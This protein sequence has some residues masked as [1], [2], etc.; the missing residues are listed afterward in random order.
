MLLAFGSSAAAQ[1][2]TAI[3]LPDIGDSSEA[4]LSS[5]DDARLGQAFMRE[6]RASVDVIDD[7]EIE[8]FIQNLGYRITAGDDAR[9]HSFFFFMVNDEAINAFAGPGGHIGV[10]TGLVLATESEDELASVLAHETAHVTQRHI[11]RA[12]ENASRNNIPALAGIIAAIALGA[13]S[14]SADAG[15]A[16]ASAIAGLQ[17]QN[18]I[19]LI[20]AN[21]KEAD[22]V[23]ME[24][25]SKADFDPRAMPA[26]FEKL[27]TSSRYYRTP[28]EFLS[29]HP[30]TTSRIADSRARAERYAYRQTPGSFDYHLTV[31]KIR[32]L[33]APSPQV[34]VDYFTKIVESG[35]HRNA[36]AAAYG[37]GL[38]LAASRRYDQAAQVLGE[39]ESKHPREP[40]FK[41]ALAAMALERGRIDEAVAKYE[42]AYRNFPDNKALVF[43]Y[44]DALLRANRGAQALDVT[45]DYARAYGREGRLYKL[46]ADAY[47]QAGRPVDS[48]LALAEHLYLDGRLDAAINQLR[49]ASG[50]TRANF[51]DGSRIAARLKALEDERLLRAQ[52]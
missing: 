4:I 5:A 3:K 50:Q 29:T 34:A 44:A 14:G 9:D 13:V 52:R 22:R 46:E 37:W 40:R 2:D 43:G 38:S 20:R 11:A 45:N 41:I 28:P 10:H 1:D 12:Y 32:V 25:L 23:G 7:P 6:V 42:A 39:L 18:Q 16:A 19:D 15:V 49:K 47:A 30:V 35:S 27:Q 26:F 24:L 8:S 48:Q 33:T 51:Y 31:A 36:D 17:V 21:E